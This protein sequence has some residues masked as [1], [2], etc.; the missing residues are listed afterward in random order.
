MSKSYTIYL[1]PSIKA[2]G[3]RTG[4]KVFLYKNRRDL[5]FTISLFHYDGLGV[6]FKKYL[7]GEDKCEVYV[8]G[9]SIEKIYLNVDWESRSIGVS[10]KESWEEYKKYLEGEDKWRWYRD[11]ETDRKSVV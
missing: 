6:K 1:P 8:N 4:L 10:S 11:W 5:S 2:G 9:D 3:G 7:E